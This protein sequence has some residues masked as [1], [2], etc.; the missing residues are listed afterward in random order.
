LWRPRCVD[1]A[2]IAVKRLSE[3]REHVE[4]CIDELV[5]SGMA[6]AETAH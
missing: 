1:L 2:Q 6:K 3:I 4:E 5:E